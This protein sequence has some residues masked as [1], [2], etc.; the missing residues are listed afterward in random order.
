MKMSAPLI[1]LAL[2]CAACSKE[3]APPAAEVAQPLEVA[4][5]EVPAGERLV[6]VGSAETEIVYALGAGEL[7]VGS[8]KSSQYPEAAAKKATLP[9][10]RMIS[11]EGVLSLSPTRLIA[12]ADAGP[13]TAIAQIEAAGVQVV[14][15]PEVR[16]V[17]GAR[18]R[19]T[20]IAQGLGEGYDA[21]SL[22]ATLDADLEAAAKRLAQCKPSKP[23]ALFVY[24]RGPGVLMVGGA[25][26]AAELMFKLAG[27]E[28]AAAGL[29]GFKPLTAEA[30]VAA[31]PEFIVFTTHGL[32][33]LGGAEGALK[34][35]GVA[36]TPAGAASRFVAVDDLRLLGMGPRMGQAVGELVEALH[37]CP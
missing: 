21:A 36:Q 19:I 22:V 7:V 25:G 10:F 30:V 12:G 34:I 14:R 17:E 15:L 32:E 33:G 9:Y 27:V 28:N 31:A 26:T 29:E 4:P 11:A 2:L 16:D 13:A 3:P 8:D 6:T 18:A 20:K 24:A 1:L 37:D 5:I 35:P 23:R